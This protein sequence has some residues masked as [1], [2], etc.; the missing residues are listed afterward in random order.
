MERS[1]TRVRRLVAAALVVLV[2]GSV[3]V[4]CGNDDGD[5]VSSDSKQATSDSSAKSYVGLTKKEAIARAE[6]SDTQWRI[7][8]EDDEV[9]MAT[10]DFVEDR[11]NFE[12]DNGKVTNATNG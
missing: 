2:L 4:A 3:A 10:Q 6:A 1:V 9:F 12:I 8:R 7:L 11:V 5:N